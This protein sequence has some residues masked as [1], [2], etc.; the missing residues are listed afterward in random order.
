MAIENVLK[1]VESN[2]IVPSD[3]DDTA[4][5]GRERLNSVMSHPFDFV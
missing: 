5:V 1:A 3:I 4:E 2:Q